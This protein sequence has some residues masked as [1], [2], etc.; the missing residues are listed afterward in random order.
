VF[1]HWI[2]L[3]C[4][5]KLIECPYQKKVSSLLFRLAAAVWLWVQSDS[6]VNAA[7]VILI[8]VSLINQVSKNFP[9][10]KTQNLGIWGCHHLHSVT[11]GNGSSNW[12][13]SW[14]HLSIWFILVSMLYWKK[15]KIIFLVISVWNTTL[16][17]T[18]KQKS[19]VC[20]DWE[21]WCYG[22]KE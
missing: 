2:I 19:P 5:L 12:N 11:F 6:C 3:G 16:D 15:E 20:F 10:A 9:E 1:F 17:D 7:D 14:F 22:L 8:H 13:P 4:L 18:P 21:K